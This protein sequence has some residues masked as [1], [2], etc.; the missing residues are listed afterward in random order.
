LS[1]ASFLFLS[2][3]NVFPNQTGTREEGPPMFKSAI[4]AV[5]MLLFAC[6]AALA[7]ETAIC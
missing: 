1:T 5:F 7:E 2:E 4:A 6:S 3:N